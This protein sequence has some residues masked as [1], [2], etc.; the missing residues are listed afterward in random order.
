MEMAEVII[1]DAGWLFFAAWGMV[2]M[3]VSV[4]AFG[5]EIL[6]VD[7]EMVERETDRQSDEMNHLPKAHEGN[8]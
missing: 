3:A 2:L 8:F 6:G 4:M 1:L 7:R 5:G